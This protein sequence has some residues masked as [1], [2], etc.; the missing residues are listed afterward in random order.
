MKYISKKSRKENYRNNLG[1]SPTSVTVT[2]SKI[3]FR[4]AHTPELLRYANVSESVSY[5]ALF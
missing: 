4:G 3:G 5:D 2:V 1:A